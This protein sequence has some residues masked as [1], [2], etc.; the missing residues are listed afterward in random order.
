MKVHKPTEKVL[1]SIQEANIFTMGSFR[2]IKNMV[3]VESSLM[4]KQ[5]VHKKWFRKT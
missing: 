4:R 3:L 2:M 1:C 5:V